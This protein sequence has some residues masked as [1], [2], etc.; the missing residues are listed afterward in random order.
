MHT[1]TLTPMHTHT[2]TDMIAAQPVCC[3]NTSVKVTPQRDEG[4]GRGRRRVGSDLPLVVLVIACNRVDYLKQTL[5]KL[6]E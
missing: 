6:L 1:H 5:D 4:E 3:S 2:H